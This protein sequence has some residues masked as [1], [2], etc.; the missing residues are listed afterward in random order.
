LNAQVDKITKE[1]SSVRNQLVDEKTAMKQHI[2]I[3]NTQLAEELR[4]QRSLNKKCIRLETECR[5]ERD[6]YQ[7]SQRLLEEKRTQCTKLHETSTK[8]QVS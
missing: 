3:T 5:E 8:T 4:K 7:K 2:R 1:L 6:K